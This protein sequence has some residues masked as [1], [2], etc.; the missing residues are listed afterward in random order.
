MSGLGWAVRVGVEMVSA[1]IVGVGVGIGLDWW[2][3]TKP[4]FL[5]VF[6]LL[7]SGAAMLNVWRAAMG[8]GLA[9]GYP[10]QGDG[11][12]EQ[13]KATQGKVAGTSGGADFNG[14]SADK[15]SER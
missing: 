13:E 7:G 11:E 14:N 15:E 2:L 12:D 8:Y 5:V 6:F 9:V 1:L 10:K 3:D 4:W